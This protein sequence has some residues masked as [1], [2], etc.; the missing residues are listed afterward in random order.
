MTEIGGVI[1]YTLLEKIREWGGV[2]EKHHQL[3][4]FFWF[5]FYTVCE[6][7]GTAARIQI[8]YIQLSLKLV[9]RRILI[10][11]N[12]YISFMDGYFFKRIKVYN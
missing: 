7:L 2:K 5:P 12:F 4:H 11:L 8:L 10:N 3:S 6:Y 1:L 9:L